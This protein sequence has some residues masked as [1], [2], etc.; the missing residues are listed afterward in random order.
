MVHCPRYQSTAWIRLSVNGTGCGGT[1]VTVP[2]LMA[3][4]VTHRSADLRHPDDGTRTKLLMESAALG[5]T[6]D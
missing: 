6:G 1:S 2:E 5:S 3:D 4:S